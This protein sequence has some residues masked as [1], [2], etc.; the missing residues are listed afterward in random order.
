MATKIRYMLALASLLSYVF[1]GFSTPIAQAESAA[2]DTALTTLNAQFE[3]T[4][5]ARPCKKALKHAWWMWRT[6]EKVELRKAQSANSELW[7]LQPDKSISYAFLMHDEKKLIEYSDVDLKM[8][9][10]AMDAKKWEALTK[11]VRQKEL[12]GMQK[13]TLKQQYQGLSLTQYDG[14]LNGVETH[15]TWVPELQIPLTMR[16]VYPKHQVTMTLLSHNAPPATLTATTEQTLLSYD[17][18]DYTDIGDMEHAA[19]AKEWL[20]KA[21]DAPG[22]NSHQH[23]H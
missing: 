5:C 13:K 10:Q 11:L 22:L 23:H 6:P 17:R 15:I 1:L 12:D 4:Q 9:N 19:S 14:K 16:Y 3:T 20:S 8:L 2:E 18:I 7:Q 21:T